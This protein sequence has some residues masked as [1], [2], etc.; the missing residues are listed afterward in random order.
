MRPGCAGTSTG[1]WVWSD[2]IA[3]EPL[4]SAEDFEAAQA[5]MIGAGRA[6]QASHETGQRVT[7]PLRPARPAVLRVLRAPNARPEQPW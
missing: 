3:Q 2:T 1:Q 7:Q 6:R 4:V 5:I